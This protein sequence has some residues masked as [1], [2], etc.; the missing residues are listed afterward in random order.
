MMVRTKALIL[1]ICSYLV[2]CGCAPKPRVIPYL[3]VVP[4][5]SRVVFA[6]YSGD[7]TII[8]LCNFLHCIVFC[9]YKNA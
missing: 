5:A 3:D 2:I 9:K 4:D 1:T 8:V 6:S 7:A